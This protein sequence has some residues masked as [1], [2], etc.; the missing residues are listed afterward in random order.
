VEVPQT[1]YARSGDVN[2]AY[3]VVGDGPFDLVF[4]PGF[5]QHV[6]LGWEEPRRRSLFERLASFSRLILYDKR[7]TGLS[8]AVPGAATLEER[9]DDIRAVLDAAGSDRAAIVGIGDGSPVTALFAATYPERVFALAL[10]AFAACWVRRPGY[11]W[12]R[13]EQEILA[14]AD[15]FEQ[16]WGTPEWVE[17]AHGI[18]PSATDEEFRV[19]AR[20]VRLSVGPKA[21]AAMQRLH[22]Q[23]DLREVLP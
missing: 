1:R 6:E 13:S 4:A 16:I 18:A 10:Y 22:A 14:S 8:D 11:P 9:M 2:I 12:G 7:G 17:L 5:A 19:F 23:M 3:Q 15:R 20:P 21:A